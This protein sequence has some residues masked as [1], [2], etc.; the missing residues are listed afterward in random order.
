MKKGRKSG[1][2][3]KKCPFDI[4][5]PAKNSYERIEIPVFNSYNGTEI[6][7][8]RRGEGTDIF[9]QEAARHSTRRRFYKSAG[10]KYGL[11]SRCR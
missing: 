2:T 6:A 1:R 3:E 7:G 4:N 8:G 9:Y 10:Y 11:L 5:D